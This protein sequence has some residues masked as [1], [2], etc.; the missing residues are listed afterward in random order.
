MSVL[1]IDSSF[2]TVQEASIL[3]VSADDSQTL[4]EFLR[5]CK[6]VS[7][8]HH[9]RSAGSKC[10]RIEAKSKR[11]PCE[12]GLVALQNLL[13]RDGIFKY[14]QWERA[15]MQFRLFYIV[16]DNH[17]VKKQLSLHQLCRLRAIMGLKRG[18]ETPAVNEATT[19]NVVHRQGADPES[20][21]VRV[22][23]LKGQSGSRIHHE[24]DILHRDIFRTTL[25]EILI[26]APV[27][28]FQYSNIY[29]GTPGKVRDFDR[30]FNEHI[31]QKPCRQTHSK[32]LIDNPAV[33]PS[34]TLKNCYAQVSDFSGQN[35]SQN[36]DLQ[37]SSVA[38]SSSLTELAKPIAASIYRRSSAGLDW[39]TQ[40]VGH[41]ALLAELSML[42]SAARDGVEYL[43]TAVSELKAASNVWLSRMLI[44]WVEI[45]Q[46]ASNTKSLIHVLL[47][48]PLPIL[49]TLPRLFTAC[50]SAESP[51]KNAVHI[52]PHSRDSPAWKS[53]LKA[54]LEKL[55]EDELS[56]VAKLNVLCACEE[57]MKGFKTSGQTS[58][59]VELVL[60]VAVLHA[61]YV[62][63][64]SIS[65]VI[66]S[67]LSVVEAN[68][69]SAVNATR[70]IQA[71]AILCD[72]TKLWRK[73]AYLSALASSLS[74]DQ[75]NWTNSLSNALAAERSLS[76][77]HNL[78][79]K[80]L[81][82]LAS[83]RC[84]VFARFQGDLRALVYANFLR[85][86]KCTRQC[87]LSSHDLSLLGR[88][89]K[90]VVKEHTILED[91][92]SV[93]IWMVDDLWLKCSMKY[94]HSFF[95]ISTVLGHEI[96]AHK[97]PVWHL[98]RKKFA[99]QVATDTLLFKPF[100]DTKDI[101]AK[102]SSDDAVDD[103]V[104]GERT[105]FKVRIRNPFHTPVFIHACRPVCVG[106]KH[107]CHD[108]ARAA[109]N[110]LR[111][112]PAN[113]VLILNLELTPLETGRIWIAG[114][115]LRVSVF[116]TTNSSCLKQIYCTLQS[117]KQSGRKTVR[118]TPNGNDTVSAV[119]PPQPCHSASLVSLPLCGFNRSS[120]LNSK[121]LPLFRK[122]RPGE[123]LTFAMVI[124]NSVS[125][126]PDRVQ[127]SA[128]SSGHMQQF[129][130]DA[131][132][133]VHSDLA[134]MNLGPL[135]SE[136]L[137]NQFLALS[138]K[139]TIVLLE[140]CSA[141]QLFGGCELSICA[142]LGKYHRKKVIRLRLR[143]SPGIRVKNSDC[144]T[145]KGEK[146][147]A[148]VLI[149]NACGASVL[150]GDESRCVILKEGEQ[151]ARLQLSFS[152]QAHLDDTSSLPLRVL[153]W[154]ILGTEPSGLDGFGSVILEPHLNRRHHRTL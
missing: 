146:H 118:Q 114:I 135:A 71:C 42:L 59:E 89:M 123:R 154:R 103:W 64:K 5:S 150:V 121:A 102:M 27:S 28:Q 17:N 117:G 116:L 147:R 61:R 4:S 75:Y 35:L 30:F 53:H 50:D 66:R 70:L 18:G 122:V 96:V 109:E 124:S 131:K 98:E 129:L 32:F 73:S 23:N 36:A 12:S 10:F 34:H 8:A 94:F 48:T 81:S 41:L 62:N 21:V 113:K 101:P 7:L 107:V 13:Q 33:L 153:E 44:T 95:N 60:K 97:C 57:A 134:E 6:K 133:M 49:L 54:S 80:Q 125:V 85:A 148:S 112:E 37:K 52:P 51:G 139:P 38:R 25:L 152:G 136:T 58:V 31:G 65:S 106:S 14:I 108:L 92:E 86:R 40:R 91:M 99:N 104:V 142:H 79:W 149:S 127:I 145:Q 144:Q 2:T 56:K 77:N 138:R 141:T 74:S 78:G 100:M 83:H 15:Y 143:A 111:V 140:V 82:M 115:I 11:F 105:L 1:N 67:I 68:W 55:T 26:R 22:V 84:V 16:C 63:K 43:A 151:D 128:H 29:S 76:H 9:E 72:R 119:V 132:E 130:V 20:C 46:S 88:I 45:A 3:L 39:K 93:S 90:P 137:Q 87:A 120:C 19:Q 126:S 47:Y 69:L 110:G 24:M